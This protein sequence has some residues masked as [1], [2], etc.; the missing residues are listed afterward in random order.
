LH[1]AEPADES[2]MEC[3]AQG[4]MRT[5]E[6]LVLRHQAAAWRIALR[7]TGDA[8]EAED[9][10][11]DTFLSI[12]NAAERYRPEAAFRTYLYRVLTRRC[13]D[14]KR[15]KRPLLFDPLPEMADP[16][17]SSPLR[18]QRQER[19][20]AI[21]AA[22]DTLPPRYRAVIVLRYFEGL[23]GQEMARILDTTPK[24]IERLLARARQRLERVLSPLLRDF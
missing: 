15:K 5:F 9:L 7:Y 17:T 24:S 2:L 21:Q 3:A 20:R 19:E 6:R 10:V 4:D 22:L 16:A 11:Q 14:Y 23:S 13:I 18:I 12:L 1:D 8:A